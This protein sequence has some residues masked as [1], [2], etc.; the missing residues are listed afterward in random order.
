MAEVPKDK[1]RVSVVIA[2][3]NELGYIEKCLD[4]FLNQTY[5]E[6]H[7]EIYVYDGNSTDG[8][9][10]YVAEIAARHPNLFLFDNPKEI[11]SVAWNLGFARSRAKY[12]VMMGAHS[13]VAEDFIEKN[14]ALLEAH[15]EVPC[16]GGIVQAIGE[17]DLSEVISLTFN[18]R[19]GVGNAR[20]RYETQQC[21]VETINYGTYRKSMID[22]IG[23]IDESLLRGQDWEYNYRIVR[24]FGKML[25]S[26]EVKVYYFSRSNLKKLWKR[27]YVAG[28]YKVRIVRRHPGSLLVRHLV[29]F[30]FTL[31]M[32]LLV[33]ATPLGLNPVFLLLY[34]GLYFTANLLV[35]LGIAR[36]SR[37]VY[38]PKL[39]I[40]FFVMHFAY[41]FGTLAGGAN[42]LLNLIQGKNR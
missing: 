14:V 2:T 1:P 42:L 17:D 16:S 6:T 30:L 38:L 34:L 32:L 37:W 41:G 11:Q 31:S 28:F 29:P 39:V 22:Q 3:K 26:P 10:E 21:F 33:L 40:T 9:S 15:P 5:P 19:F 35:S 25:F 24:K 12:V 8:S 18:S 23:E 4:S 13:Y 20:Y 7:Y 27:Q 36:K